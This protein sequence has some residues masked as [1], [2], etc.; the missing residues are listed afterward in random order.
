MFIDSLG[1]DLK[2]GLLLINLLE[3]LSG[4]SLG[5]YNKHPRIPIQKIENTAQV[6]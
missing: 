2:D 4:K 6:F 5:R 1:Q 3:L